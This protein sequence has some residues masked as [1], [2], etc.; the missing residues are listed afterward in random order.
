MVHHITGDTINKYKTPAEDIVTRETW[1]ASF[2]GY[3]IN[4]VQGN[5]NTKAAGI[6]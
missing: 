1:T 3:F 2:G 6:Y 4:L 5:N